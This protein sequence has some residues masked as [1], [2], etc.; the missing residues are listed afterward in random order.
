MRT[1]N[2]ELMEKLKQIWASYKAA[3]NDKK[4]P[5]SDHSNHSSEQVNM[6]EMIKLT[7]FCFLSLFSSFVQHFRQEMNTL[8]SNVNYLTNKISNNNDRIGNENTYKYEQD[9]TNQG[10]LNMA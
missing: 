5:V 10:I 6:R 9:I 8:Q 7:V 3:V 2:T 1:T 4:I